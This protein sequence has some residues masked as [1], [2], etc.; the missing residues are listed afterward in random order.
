MRGET[1]LGL[2][3]V[4]AA[5]MS[6]VVAPPRASA[7]D[8]SFT[9]YGDAADGWGPTSDNITNPGPRLVVFLGDVV[10]LTLIGNDS[11]LHNWFIDYDNDTIDDPEEPDSDDFQGTTRFFEF[12]AARVGTWTYRCRIHP[13]TMTGVFEVRAGGRPRA[14]TLVGDAADGW[15]P[16]A[17]NV[18]NPGPVLV[19]NVGDT[20]TLTLIGNDSALHNWFIDYD[21]D[22]IDDPEEPDSDD[23]QGV[24]DT[25][26]FTFVPDRAGTWTYRC[27]I[28]PTTMTGLLVVRG[29]PTDGGP[30]G[31]RIDLIQAILLATIAFVLLFAAGYHLRAVRA[32]RRSK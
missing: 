6:L 16:D 11:A 5:V 32:H 4:A 1:V 19:T 15:G 18:T 20:V 22:T 25:V 12:T 21:N 26:T 17:R 10:N 3:V 27:R 2:F 29:T 7:A 23:F 28:H 30:S 8:W 31:F 13:T 14:F 24:G 9:L